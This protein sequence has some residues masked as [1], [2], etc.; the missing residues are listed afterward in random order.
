MVVYKEQVA[1]DMRSIRAKVLG[2]PLNVLLLGAG[3][4]F[5]AHRFWIS[6]TAGRAAWDRL[7]LK[8]PMVGLILKQQFL[9]QFLETLSTLLSNGV[10]LLN[11]LI[12]VGNATGNTHIKTVIAHLVTDVCEGVPLSRSMK[13]S[14]FFPAVLIDI[15]TVGEQTGKISLALQRGAARYDKEFNTQIQRLTLLIQPVTILCVAIFVGVIAYSMIT[16]ILTTVSG[17]RMH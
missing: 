1:S 15:V 8:L 14:G 12:L 4:V 10:A 16:G 2:F 17:L 13:K 9:A 11:A 6:T 5:L 7:K 3:V